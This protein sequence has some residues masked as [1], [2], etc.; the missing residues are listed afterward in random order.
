[1]IYRQLGNITRLASVLGN[2]GA[3]AFQLDD[4]DGAESYLI[5][6]LTFHR[7]MGATG[8]QPAPLHMAVA[9][10]NLADI[11]IKRADWRRATEF[12][13]ESLAI[14]QEMNHR[15]GIANGL[16]R[17]PI[18]L[19]G[20][21]RVEDAA[22]LLGAAESF[23]ATVDAA[24][25]PED[26]RQLADLRQRLRETLGEAELLA[27]ETRGQATNLGAAVEIAFRREGSL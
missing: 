15:P 9:L 8:L 21:S 7:E 13:R 22:L 6:S 26:A 4:L 24:R 14:R 20:V 16:D 17:V 1:L 18:I 19:E 10:H 2:L 12:L 3:N 27:Q 23:R 25:S 5:E 11:A